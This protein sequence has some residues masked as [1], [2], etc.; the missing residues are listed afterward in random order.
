MQKDRAAEARW[1]EK[2]NRWCIQVQSNGI[3][4]RFYSS[5]VGAKG[6]VQAERKADEWLSEDAIYG[7]MTVERAWKGFVEY[8]KDEDIQTHQYESI[9]KVHIL[10]VLSRF[11]VSSLT[12]FDLQRILTNGYN[13]G[14]SQKSLKNIRGCISSFM[15]YCRMRRFTTL[16]PENI[17]VNK[18]AKKPNKKTMQP[19]EIKILFSADKT[20]WQGKECFDWYVYAYRFQ[21]SM[22]LRPSELL[23]LKRSDIDDENKSI[24]IRGGY[25]GRGRFSDGKTENAARTIYM[26]EI[27]YKVYKEQIKML[28]SN[29]K[30]VRKCPYLFP[31]RTGKICETKTLWQNFSR[32][33]EHNGINHYSLYELRHTYI[34][35]NRYMPEA[36]LKLQ[37]GHSEKMDTRGVYGHEID[38]DAR[39]ASELS[40]A[41][42]NEILG[43][44]S[45]DD[46]TPTE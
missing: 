9:G 8:M 20:I 32:F 33:C 14:L 13:K 22:G 3:R 10:P 41:A 7:K 25:L 4:R 6:K 42:F 15:K 27:S 44:T 35:V 43:I 16:H 18:K 21:A 31:D 26:N 5:I 45:E 28:D 39:R 12:E 46:L 37:V 36:L 1:I 40:T 19:D 30:I 17:K 38:G 23:G 2:E 11:K 29:K 34:S 24:T